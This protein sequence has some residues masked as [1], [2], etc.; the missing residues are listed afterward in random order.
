MGKVNHS[1]T[2]ALITSEIYH[3]DVLETFIK[4]KCKSVH[5]FIWLS[6]LCFGF[7]N[8]GKCFV[9]QM[10]SGISQCGCL[11]CFDELNRMKIKVISVI[12][13]QVTSIFDAQETNKEYYEFMGANIKCSLDTGIFFT[14][15]P[16]YAA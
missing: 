4:G 5:D 13:L 10:N 11:G 9:K 6:Q 1:K 15:N 7:N 16:D 14:F 3:R 12:A 8:T 2:V